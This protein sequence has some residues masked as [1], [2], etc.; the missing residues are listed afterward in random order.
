MR[1]WA[2]EYADADQTLLDP[3]IAVMQRDGDRIGAVEIPAGWVPIANG[4]HR[5]LCAAIGTYVVETAGQKGLGLRYKILMPERD[6]PVAQALIA[7]AR[8]ATMR[9]CTVC[10]A[11]TTPANPPRC[12]RHPRRST[13]HA[14]ARPPWWQPPAA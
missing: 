1:L 6:H 7:A 2:D 10:G 11:P 9:I 8:E 14:I 4:L 13:P 12:D 5:D 3:S